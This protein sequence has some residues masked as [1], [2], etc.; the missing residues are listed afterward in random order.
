MLILSV[1]WN[2]ACP[3]HQEAR[4]LGSCQGQQ[5]CRNP[6]AFFNVR[7]IVIARKFPIDN[8]PDHPL[9]SAIDSVRRDS[10]GLI[11]NA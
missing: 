9:I 2:E 11:S 3:L 1:S 8:A 7:F 6:K 4:G 10:V 5:L